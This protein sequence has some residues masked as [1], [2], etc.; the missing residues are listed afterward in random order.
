[1]SKATYAHLVPRE[2]WEE[3]TVAVVTV[4]S[5]DP[6]YADTRYLSE[7]V[8]ADVIRGM[9]RLDPG[10]ALWQAVRFAR[11]DLNVGDFAS[12]GADADLAAM[13]DDV[14]ELSVE[15]FT[16]DQRAWLFDDRLI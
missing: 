14:D 7:R 4:V 10:S 15:V 12:T 9:S 6:R 5:S 16:S 11:D 8:K 13:L 2:S 1:M 3:S